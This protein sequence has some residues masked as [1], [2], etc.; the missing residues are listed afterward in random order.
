MRAPLASPR[1]DMVP[2][3]SH[4]NKLLAAGAIEPS[5]SE[6]ASPVVLVSKPGGGLRF[7]VDYRK[8]NAMTIKDSYPLPKMDESIDSLGEAEWFVIIFS[9]GIEDHIQE[10]DDILR[11]LGEADVSLNFAKCTFFAKEIVYLG[12]DIKPG[13]LEIQKAHTKCLR[14]TNPPKT[15]TE[16]RSFLGA[17]NVFRRF[18]RGNSRIAAPLY[19]LLAVLPPGAGGNNSKHPIL[20]EGLALTA[21]DNLKQALISPPIL[22]LPKENAEM[23]I[24]MGAC[25]ISIGIALFQKEEDGIRYPMGYWSTILNKSEKNYSMMEK[26]CLALV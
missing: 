18:I 10:V 25:S 26:E 3:A 11:M 6:W 5:Q 12:H 24:D 13:R 23:S 1:T 7:C 19:N 8:L 21:F 2:Q 14:D 4:L 20:I 17:C 22:A 9:K 15:V 16:L